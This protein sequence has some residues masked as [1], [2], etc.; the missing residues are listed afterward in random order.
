[1]LNK[2]FKTEDEHEVVDIYEF[3][4]YY[5]TFFFEGRLERCYVEW[6]QRM[7][8]CAGTC[9]HSSHQSCT[10]RLSAP[11]LKYRTAN[12]LKE[13]LLHEMIHAFPFLTNPSAC[14]DH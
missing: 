13:T 14:L 3:F 7:T 6:S 8:L 11:I 12:E 9:T 5:N 4:N 10:I 1:M 2:Y